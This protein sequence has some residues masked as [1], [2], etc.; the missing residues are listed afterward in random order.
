MTADAAGIN[1]L[2]DAKQWFRWKAC[3]VSAWRNDGWN[4]RSCRASNCGKVRAMLSGNPDPR[5]CS[6]FQAHRPIVLITPSSVVTVKAECR[7]FGIVGF[8]CNNRQP[9]HLTVAADGHRCVFVRRQVHLTSVSRATFDLGEQLDGAPCEL[10]IPALVLQF[11]RCVVV[12]FVE[13]VVDYAASS[14]RTGLPVCPCDSVYR[15]CSR[16]QDS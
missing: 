1:G 3:G 5:P 11:H 10:P 15:P 2:G 6:L 12:A 4:A 7:Q 9:V 14:G 8:A 13:V 16:S